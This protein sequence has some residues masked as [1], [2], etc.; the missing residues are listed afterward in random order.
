MTFRWSWSVRERETSWLWAE[1][2]VHVPLENDLGSMRHPCQGK[3]CFLT[4]FPE[5]HCQ[6]APHGKWRRLCGDPGEKGSQGAQATW[7]ATSFGS[8]DAQFVAWYRAH[9]SIRSGWLTT[10]GRP[11]G[12]CILPASTAAYWRHATDQTAWE[13]PRVTEGAWPWPGKEGPQ[14]HGMDRR[15]LH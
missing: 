5:L 4:C 3:S 1:F 15:L 8:L 6:A 7:S 14:S 9:I 11:A 2:P 12:G 10:K 13:I